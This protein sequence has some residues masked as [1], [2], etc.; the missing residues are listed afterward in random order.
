MATPSSFTYWIR[1][2]FLSW[3]RLI[4]IDGQIATLTPHFSSVLQRF[5]GHF[6]SRFQSAA[7][8][9]RVWQRRIGPCP[10]FDLAFV[11]IHG[12]ISNICSSFHNHFHLI[13]YPNYVQFPFTFFPLRITSNFFLL[14]FGPI[15]SNFWFNFVS[16]WLDFCPSFLQTLSNSSEYFSVN[17]IEILSNFYLN[18]VWVIGKSF[19]F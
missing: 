3:F 19:F 2:R 14:N 18:M 13:I 12:Q 1:L 17:F 16:I 6:C 9:S 11:P 7:I 5:Y 15:P 8:I 10:S 4:A